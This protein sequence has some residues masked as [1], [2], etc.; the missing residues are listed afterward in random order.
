MEKTPKKFV[1]ENPK[2]VS[3][4]KPGDI[5]WIN[6]IA[7]YV[8]SDGVMFTHMYCT[9]VDRKSSIHDVVHLNQ[10]KTNYSFNPSHICNIKIEMLPSKSYQVDLSGIDYKWQKLE[11]KHTH[12]VTAIPVVVFEQT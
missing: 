9:V 11:V 3:E 2:N 7:L 1:D 12:W 10:Y 8:D 5:R 6:P 4:M